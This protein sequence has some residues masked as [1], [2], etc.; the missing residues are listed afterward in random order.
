LGL[1]AFVAKFLDKQ[2]QVS[3]LLRSLLR[4]EVDWVW[5]LVQ[6][7]AF[8]KLGLYG[9]SGSGASLFFFSCQNNCFSGRLLARLILGVVLLQ[10]QEDGRWASV[11]YTSQ[12]LTP[13]K[14]NYG[15]TVKEALAMT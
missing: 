10:E 1:V 11:M 12:A 3:E 8:V 6:E 2:S 9:H 7:E 14:Q 13:T 4:N 5:S 15:Q